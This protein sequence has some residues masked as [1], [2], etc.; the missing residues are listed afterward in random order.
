MSNF[1]LESDKE[2]KARDLY[3]TY[4]SN[5]SSN[6]IFG[7]GKEEPIGESFV[8]LL[9]FPTQL[10]MTLLID[11]LRINHMTLQDYWLNT[12]QLTLRFRHEQILNSA[13][14]KL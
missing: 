8:P 12:R 4:V 5:C 3:Q 7:S 10:L 11:H 9:F 13:V 2:A 14:S 1:D 6:L